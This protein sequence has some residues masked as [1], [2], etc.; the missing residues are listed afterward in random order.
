MMTL[1]QEV[2]RDLGVTETRTS[3]F[4]L[5]PSAWRKT[6]KYWFVLAVGFCLGSITA[7]V[8]SVILTFL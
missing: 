4:K 5:G 8:I 2:E 6:M 1:R 3:R 7:G